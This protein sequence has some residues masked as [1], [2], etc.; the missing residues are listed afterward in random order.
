MSWSQ[1]SGLNSDVN[2]DTSTCNYICRSDNIV[3]ACPLTF[4]N[5][6]DACSTCNTPSGTLADILPYIYQGCGIDSSSHV[7][8]YLAA[9]STSMTPSI[10]YGL[11]SN[12]FGSLYFGLQGTQCYCGSSNPFALGKTGDASCS[13]KCGGDNTKYCGNTLMNSVYLNS[14]PS[15]ALGNAKSPNFFLC[16]MWC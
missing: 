6:S 4:C 14:L 10:C 1:I 9:Q 7:L 16:C 2:L 13:T 5:N 15:D 8:P 11:C 12:S 3:P